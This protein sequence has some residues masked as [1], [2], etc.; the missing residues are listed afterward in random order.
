M[1]ARQTG[2]PYDKDIIATIFKH[3]LAAAFFA[4]G[5]YL[6]VENVSNAWENLFG[7]KTRMLYSEHMSNVH[8]SNKPKHQEGQSRKM[9]D[10]HGGEKG[11]K[12]RKRYK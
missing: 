11:D 2:N 3:A 12:R 5:V 8:K 9:R 1:S 4:V 6:T 7:N 10:N